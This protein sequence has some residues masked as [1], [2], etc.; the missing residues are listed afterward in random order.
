[1]WRDI[2]V[3]RGTPL[4]LPM[5]VVVARYALVE[6]LSV[7]PLSAWA[8]NNLGNLHFDVKHNPKEARQMYKKA[9]EIDPDF[10]DALVNYGPSTYLIIHDL[11]FF[12]VPSG[13]CCL[14]RSHL[15]PS[16]PSIFLVL[17]VF[18]ASIVFGS[19]LVNPFVEPWSGPLIFGV[20]W[21]TTRTCNCHRPLFAIREY[22]QMEES[23]GGS[24][25]F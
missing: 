8:L 18:V 21:G 17:V 6:V 22:W 24:N 15:S 20:R 19:L 16:T 12:L 9:L 5:N 23:P 7:E 14:L 1:M 13:S 25:P 10:P 2:D 3:A 4:L 11:H